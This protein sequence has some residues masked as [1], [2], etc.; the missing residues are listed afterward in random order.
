MTDIAEIFARS[1][2]DC[3]DDDMRAIIAAFRERR[4]QFNLGNMAAGSTKATTAKAKESI[5]AT[6]KLDL[7]SIG[8]LK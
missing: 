6:G 7:R 2:D 1:P 4:K 5:S 3:T 8:L